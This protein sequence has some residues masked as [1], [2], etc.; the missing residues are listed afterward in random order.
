M[1]WFV[2]CWCGPCCCDYAALFVLCCVVLCCAA[3]CGACQAR[4]C[5]GVSRRDGAACWVGLDRGG[6]RVSVCVGSRVFVVF[7]LVYSIYIKY[8]IYILRSIEIIYTHKY[9]YIY[10][11]IYIY[12]SKYIYTRYIFA[13]LSCDK[14]CCV[15]LRFVPHGL[16]HRTPGSYT[17][18]LAIQTQRPPV[19]RS[20]LG[21]SYPLCPRT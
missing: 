1:L 21:N 17:P 9:I 6:G 14:A 4:C 5:C 18:P 20:A 13:V 3:R 11:Y 8:S 19:R 10:I 16:H 2:C 15:V 7:L 12:T